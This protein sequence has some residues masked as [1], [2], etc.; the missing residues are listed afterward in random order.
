MN[1]CSACCVPASDVADEAP[2]P[3][4][5]EVPLALAVPEVLSEDVLESRDIPMLE[6]A[7]VIALMSPPSGGEGGGPFA[8]I[9]WLAFELDE[10][11]ETLDVLN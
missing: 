9:A 1:D 10:P 2:D 8:L 6:R 11:F 3:E 7:C 4:M 5:S